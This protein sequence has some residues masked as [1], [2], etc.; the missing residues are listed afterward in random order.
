MRYAYCALRS[1]PATEAPI[2]DYGTVKNGP[3]IRATRQYDLG[4]PSTCSA[5]KLRIRFVEIGATW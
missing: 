3:S 4:R 2:P 5:K 1:S